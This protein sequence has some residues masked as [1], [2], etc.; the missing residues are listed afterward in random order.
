MKWLEVSLT[1]RGEIAEA[2][3]DVLAR[4]APGGLVLERIKHA[5]N[6]PF[7]AG[8]VKLRAF[9]LADEGLAERRRLIQEGIW[10]LG[11]IMPIPE[12]SYQW[13]EKDDWNEVWKSSYQPLPIGARLLVQPSWIPKPEG[14]RLIISIDPGMAFGTG[15]HPSTRL[16]LQALEMHTKPGDTLADLG[17]G[18][19]ILSIAA[20]R[21]GAARVLAFDNDPSAV[22]VARANMVHN[23]VEEIVMVEQGSLPELL[24]AC[25]RENER[26]RILVANIYAAVLERM[27]EDGLADGVQTGGLVI[28]AGILIEQTGGIRECAEKQGLRFQQVTTETDWQAL[29]LTRESPP[30]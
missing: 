30:M 29:L 2:I 14:D 21:L 16:C 17:C 13:I 4:H 3:A 20:A 19:G 11:R 5:T 22:K 1:A 25:D 26:P 7:G 27:L 9:L 24:A 15:V 6:E 10:H 23:D 12:L 18:S 28:L 8:A